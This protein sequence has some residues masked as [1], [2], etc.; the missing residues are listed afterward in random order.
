MSDLN[1]N[2]LHPLISKFKCFFHSHWIDSIAPCW[3]IKLASIVAVAPCWQTLLNIPSNLVSLPP[4]T[5]LQIQITTRWWP[6][7]TKICQFRMPM[8]SK[9]RSRIIPQYLESVC[10]WGWTAPAVITFTNSFVVV[11]VLSPVGVTFRIDTEAP[12]NHQ[13]QNE[14]WATD[15]GTICCR[16]G[17]QQSEREAGFSNRKRHCDQ[18]NKQPGDRDRRQVVDVCRSYCS[19][20]LMFCVD[21]HGNVYSPATSQLFCRLDRDPWNTLNILVTTTESFP[22]RM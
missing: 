16:L 6:A 1:G 4:R 3:R 10:T 18:P 13:Q 2:Y 9:S 21:P 12:T 5:T 20:L 17:S 22:A 7:R 19:S 15:A 8:R 11:V 14:V